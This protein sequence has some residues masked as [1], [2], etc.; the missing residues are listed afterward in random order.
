MFNKHP[1]YLKKELKLIE[2][3]L[4]MALDKIRATFNFTIETLY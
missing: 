2:N 3:Q 4:V 1:V